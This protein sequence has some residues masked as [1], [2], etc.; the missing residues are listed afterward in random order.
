MQ[1][2][3]RYISSK[4]RLWLSTAYARDSR[5]KMPPLLVTKR[6]SLRVSTTGSSP[7]RLRSIPRCQW[8]PL[9]SKIRSLFKQFSGN[10]SSSKFVSAFLSKNAFKR[11][12]KLKK[13]FSPKTSTPWSTRNAYLRTHPA[14]QRSRVTPRSEQSM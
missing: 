4:S 14:S 1:R 12:L 6:A 2:A 9:S 3:C 10:L 8:I 5:S 13:R 11:S 7:S